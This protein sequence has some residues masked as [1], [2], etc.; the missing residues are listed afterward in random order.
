MTEDTAKPSRRTSI[1]RRL[2]L[3]A[4]AATL[5]APALLAAAT[6]ALAVTPVQMPAQGPGFYRT[7]VGDITVTAVHD[8]FALR[9]LEGFVRNA[10]LGDVQEAMKKA[11]LPTTAF[12]N[13]F[14][15]LVVQTGGK[16][17]LIDTGNGNTGAPTSGTW[18]Q[19]FRAAGFAPEMVDQIIISHFHG[20]HINGLRFKDGTSA[21]TKAEISV[22]APE[23]DFWMS[24][25][26]MN[27]APDAAR[28]GFQNARRVFQPVA[29]QVKR[30][31][32]GAEVAPGITSFAAHGHTPGH[33]I[34][35][36]SSGN[37]RLMFVAD[38]T[39]HPALFVRNP[40][41]AVIFDQ[42]ADMARQTRR[43]VLDMAASERTQLAFYHAPFPATGFIAKEGNGYEFVPVQWTQWP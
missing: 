8:G 13:T 27:Q 11:F 4:G 19:N 33:T 20:D 32:P 5:A 25:E 31:A 37:A 29:A 30:F 28:G 21:F 34:F 16:I 7:K 35:G 24:D 18:M 9:P 1:D 39:N 38:I 43:R 14:T 26:R 6:P 10:P 2:A 42:D 12:Q 41:W 15:A 23:W 22:P 36:I 3:A 17:V 40:D